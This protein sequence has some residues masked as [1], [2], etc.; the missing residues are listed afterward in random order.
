MTRSIDVR[1]SPIAGQWY[2]GN[3]D[4][5]RRQINRYL[6]GA[7]IPKL[8]GR[9]VALI[10]PHAGLRYSGATAGYAFRTIQDSVFDTVAILSPYH[11]YHPAPLLT[12][13]HSAYSTPLGIVPVD[14]AAFSI[15]E[16]EVHTHTGIGFTRLDHDEEHSLEIELPFLQVALS[17]P[18]TLLPLML[19]TFSRGLL[20]A[21][22]QALGDALKDRKA[23]LIASTDLSHFFPL[24]QANQLDAEMLNCIASFSPEKVLQA[25]EEETAFACGAPAVATVLWAARSLGATHVHVLHHS[26]SAEVTRDASSVVGY[27]AAAILSPD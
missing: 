17:G 9:V 15:L 13:S 2:E 16:K 18:F 8:K 24:P 14:K 26:T 10:T 4:A 20:Q 23:L 27:G 22:G 12:T 3:A 21:L 25:E 19:R 1:P 7:I 5:L 6:A 11:D